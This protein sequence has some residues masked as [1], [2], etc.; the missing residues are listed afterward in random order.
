MGQTWAETALAREQNIDIKS[1]SL[2]LKRLEGK[3]ENM[4]VFRDE[5]HSAGNLLCKWLV[6][7]A[8]K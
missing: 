8:C 5:C 6:L 2:A 3:M 7:I 1:T 4:P